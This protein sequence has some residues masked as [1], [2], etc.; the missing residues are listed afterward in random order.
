M[1]WRVAAAWALIG[2]ACQC[3]LAFWSGL[4]LVAGLR[5]AI[6]HY[7]AW[8]FAGFLAGSMTERLVEEAFLRRFPLPHT[9]ESTSMPADNAESA[10]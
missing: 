7:V 1:G 2:M 3:F 9:I 4:E 5:E 8:G 6:L 10:K